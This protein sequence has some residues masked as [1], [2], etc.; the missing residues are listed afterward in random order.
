MT[1][2][3]K[4]IRSDGFSDDGTFSIALI[5]YDGFVASVSLGYDCIEEMQWIGESPKIS[6][7]TIYGSPYIAYDDPKIRGYIY[8][9]ET[10]E[11][12]GEI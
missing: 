11:L 2:W 3:K 12:E 1:K 8:I 10:D 7:K 6:F 5:N 4:R 9:P